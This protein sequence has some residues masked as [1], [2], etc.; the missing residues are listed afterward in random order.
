MSALHSNKYLPYYFQTGPTPPPTMT[1][2]V[3]GKYFDEQKNMINCNG[4]LVIDGWVKSEQSP[5]LALYKVSHAWHPN[6]WKFTFDHNVPEDIREF[7][8]EQIVPVAQTNFFANAAQYNEGAVILRDKAGEDIGRGFAEAVQYSDPTSNAYHILGYSDKPVLQKIL[9]K[10][11]ASVFG[12]I[13]SF[14]YTMTHQKELKEVISKA[15]GME[16][17]GAKPKKEKHHHTSRY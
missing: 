15:K 14:L 8:M 3:A 6:N 11:D 13:S 2:P 10:K 9:T 7:S 1:V 12:K 16:L 4:T 17:L 5:N